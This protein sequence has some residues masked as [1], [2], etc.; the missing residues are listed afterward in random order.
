MLP[1]SPHPNDEPAFV[2][3]NTLPRKE[4]KKQEITKKVVAPPLPKIGSLKI[5]VMHGVIYRNTEL[6]GEMDPFILI[7]HKKRKYKTKASMSAG[8]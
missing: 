4:V 7:L 6:F 3:K 2:K 1:V 8:N 5:K